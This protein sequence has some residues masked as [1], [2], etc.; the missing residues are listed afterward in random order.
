MFCTGGNNIGRIGVLQHVEKHSASF[1]IAHVKDAEGNTFATRVN[2]I[3]SIGEGKRPM[4]SI[5][6]GRGIRKTNLEERNEKMH[7]E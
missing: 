2:N 1:D 6:R 5:P 4:I 7:N 3:F